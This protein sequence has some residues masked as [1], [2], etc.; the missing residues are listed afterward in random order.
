MRVGHGGT[1]NIISVCASETILENGA[2]LVRI[3]VK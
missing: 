1:P 2:H 3:F